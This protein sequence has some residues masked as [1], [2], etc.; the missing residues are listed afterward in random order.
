MNIK[1]VPP[2]SFTVHFDHWKY[3]FWIIVPTLLIWVVNDDRTSEVGLIYVV[4]AMSDSLVGKRALV[5]GSSGGIGKAIAIQ[6]AREGASVLIH[7]HTR[8]E[9]A[10][11]T[12][13]EIRSICGTDAAVAGI[14]QCDFRN[15]IAIQHMFEND[16]DQQIWP[17]SSSSSTTSST[18]TT[19]RTTATTTT[20]YTTTIPGQFDILVNNAGIVLKQA[21]DDDTL[22]NIK[23][24]HECLAVNLHA[25]RILS[26]YAF[27]RFQ[28]AANG[29]TGGGVI[30]NVG[31]YV[32]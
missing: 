15:P 6:L 18:T 9:G 25:P 19:S 14:V 16:I 7:Y 11:N 13:A 24:W 26:Q 23:H 17:S 3:L 1:T 20:A 22:P 29:S 12:A 8:K 27:Q 30:L 32:T 28:K 5:T 21:I 2:A 10:E 31:R 4:A